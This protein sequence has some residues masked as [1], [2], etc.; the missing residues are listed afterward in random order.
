M[1]FSVITPAETPE[2]CMPY[3]QVDTARCSYNGYRSPGFPTRETWRR[4]EDTPEVF[5]GRAVHYHPGI[6]RATALERGFSSRYLE[7]F[8]C[9]VSGFYINDVGR[10]A[11]MLHDGGEP[12]CL[13]VDNAR[14]RDLWETLVLNREA[15]E[16]SYRFWQ[17]EMRE[18]KRD[19]RFPVVVMAYQVERPTKDEWLSA[20]RMDAH[21]ADVCLNGAAA[22]L[23]QP[24]DTISSIA[25]AYYG[26]S[27][28]AYWQ[29]IRFENDGLVG[30]GYELDVGTTL[31]IPMWEE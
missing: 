11:W 9:L 28:P 24:G 16:V 15:V 12:R 30:A 3:Q 29:M 31:K 4:D 7:Q 10:V 26:K 18:D 27:K 22:R 19:D 20:Q 2:A 5:Y 8:D 25:R 6:M 14:P 13:V 1:M 21:L 23:V 17:D